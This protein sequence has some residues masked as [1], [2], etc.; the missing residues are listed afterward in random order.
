MIAAVAWPRFDS[1]GRDPTYFIQFG[2]RYRDA[3][4]HAAVVRGSSPRRLRRPVLLAQAL[5]RG[6]RRS[7]PFDGLEQVR[8]LYRALRMA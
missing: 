8:Q 5:S 4:L 6:A 7:R 1:H 3:V 2:H